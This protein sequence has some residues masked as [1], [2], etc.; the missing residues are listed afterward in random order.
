MVYKYAY[1]NVPYFNVP[2]HCQLYEVCHCAL[3]RFELDNMSVTA[4]ETPMSAKPL[5]AIDTL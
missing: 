2:A 1:F 5:S 3:S 4:A